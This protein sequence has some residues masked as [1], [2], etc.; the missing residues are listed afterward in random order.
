MCALARVRVSEFM[1]HGMKSLDAW[2]DALHI[3]ALL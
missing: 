1:Y 3:A 2:Y